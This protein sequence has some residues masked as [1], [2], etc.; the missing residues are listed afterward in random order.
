MFDGDRRNPVTFIL[1]SGGR[2]MIKYIVGLVLAVVVTVAISVAVAIPI[3]KQNAAMAAAAPAT[4]EAGY[5]YSLTDN[6]K[7]KYLTTTLAD[8]KTI[9]LQ[10]IIELDASL[11]PKDQK[12]PDRKMLVLQDTLLRTLRELKSNDLEAGNQEAFKRRISDVAG[13]VLGRHAVLGVYL[14]GATLQMSSLDIVPTAAGV[15]AQA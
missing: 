2:E 4:R 8:G 14:I 1:P 3:A 15:R 5:M 6:D 12:N 9:R 7:S 10:L 11:A 13:K